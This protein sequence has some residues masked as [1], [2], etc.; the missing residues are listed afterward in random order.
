[1][2][3][4]IMVIL[5][6]VLTTFIGWYMSQRAKAQNDIKSFFIGK[7]ELGTLLIM[8]VM[9]GEMVA[10]SSTVGS[11]QT[12]FNSGMSSVWT[13]WGQALG[14]FVFVAT[15]SKLY[16][17][18]GHYGAYSVPEAFQF[19]FDSKPCR[20]VVMVIVVVVYGI[21]YAMQPKAAG[22]VLAPMLNVDLT[23]MTWIMG[24]IFI[25]Q[26]LV[27][28]KGIAA[29][30]VVHATVLYVG[31][32]VVGILAWHNVGSLDVVR[33]T[34][35]A[36][37]L[38]VTQ[39]SLGAVI[40]NAAGG[41]FAFIL[42]TSLVANVYSAKS[43]KAANRGVVL[44]AVLVIIFAFFP[45]LIG[46]FGKI[47][48]PDAEAATIFY[49]VADTFGPAVGALAS[50]AIIAAVF[51]T[52]PAFLLTISTTLTRDFY[53]AL[54]NK[55]A[56][57]KQ[58]LRFSKIALIV[59]GL[60]ATFLGI[61]ARSILSQVNGAFQIRAVAGMVLI[62]GA[63]WK[64][65]DKKSAFWAMLVGGLVAAVWHFAGQPFGIVPFWPGC[66]TGLVVLVVMTLCNGKEVSDDFA[67]YKSR[68]DAVPA[69]EL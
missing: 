25:I 6:I 8:F 20:M 36:N 42:S 51:S 48:Y 54:I 34:L 62:I 56:T 16:R 66:G 53:V 67:L 50:M 31:S 17:V 5:Y 47:M 11:A 24:I 29:M 9:F 38:S 3:E 1:M 30:N 68:M 61:Y 52:A 37:Y 22:A 32:V 2:L 15:V 41:M 27:G 63:Y 19:R 7:K 60:V 64:K 43:K 26:G 46:V 65:V 57:D 21:L 4:F 39:P 33:E 23:A 59:F 55:D 13:N 28:L 45:A 58:Q 18:A 40:G 10:G 44:A 12:A 35:G 69:D 14:V 49:T